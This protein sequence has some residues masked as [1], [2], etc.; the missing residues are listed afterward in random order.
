MK[1]EDRTIPPVTQAIGG[2][3]GGEKYI[4]SEQGIF[5]KFAVCHHTICNAQE[6]M[7]ET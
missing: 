2:I 7:L 6:Q 4:H 5:F 3:A 1:P